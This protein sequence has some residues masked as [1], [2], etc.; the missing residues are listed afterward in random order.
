MEL[1][2]KNID[3]ANVI[4]TSTIPKDLLDKN[5]NKVAL[6]TSKDISIA[7]FRKGKVPLSVVKQR[8][9]DSLVEEAQSE[10]LRDLFQKALKNLDV[11]NENIIGEP[12]VSKF[13]KKEDGSIDVEVKLYLKPNINLGD[14]KSLLPEIKTKKV[15]AK[16]VTDRLD[17][18]AK[19]SAPLETV[20][21]KRAVKQND[22]VVIDFEG[23]INGIAF[24]GGKA[25]KHSLQVGSQSFIPG[26]EDQIID[27]KCTEEKDIKVTFPQEYNSK[28]LAGK[29]AIFK[30]KLLEIQK[31]ATVIL[32]DEFAK[33]IL[34][35]EE[36]A[37]LE[38]LKE[39]IKEEIKAEKNKLYYR[40]ELKPLY[41]DTLVK[42]LNFPVPQSLVE[43]EV[44]MVLNNKVNQY[45][46]KEI[47]KLQ[48]NPNEVEKLREELKPDATNSVKA[49]FIIDALS[50]AENIKVTDQEVSQVIFY[51][52]MQ[53]GQNPQEALKAYKEKGYLNAIKMS[54][55][56]E[57]VISKLLDEKKLG[58]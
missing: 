14:Y 10:A 42:Q 13:D 44:N 56:E 27:M 19:Q 7:G 11:K 3:E 35:G 32:D 40:D 36:N 48:E 2:I 30:V 45:S 47:K 28:D 39:K 24:D 58:K 52:A 46:Q 37:S 15:I 20:K 43:Q 33:K 31:K 17:M 53:T 5:F 8:H 12:A 18:I 38:I 34:Q 51:E 41:L 22:Y 54:M 23:F 25:Q 21:T 4:I 26:F 16:D 1:N 55:M 6:Q 49:T 29:E 50:K 57:K 9:G